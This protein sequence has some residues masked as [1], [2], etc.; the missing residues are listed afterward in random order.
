MVA[1]ATR[2]TSTDLK[3]YETLALLRKM[4]LSS[5]DVEAAVL[6]IWEKC[7]TGVA[8]ISVTTDA[9][10][11]AEKVMLRSEKASCRLDFI[12]GTTIGTKSL[13][14]DRLLVVVAAIA[15]VSNKINWS[16]GCV[17]INLDDSGGPDEICFSSHH[18][19]SWLIP[20]TDFLGSAAYAHLRGLLSAEPVA[21]TRK[22]P[23]AF[24][25]GASTGPRFSN[26][27]SQIRP[28]RDL[29]RIRVC[30]MAQHGRLSEI[31]DAGISHLV[32]LSESEKADVLLEGVVRERVLQRAFADYKVV[33]DIDG[34]ANAWASLFCKLLTGS[35]VLKVESEFGFRQ[36]YY[37]HLIAGEHFV[38]VRADLSDLEEQ[39]VWCLEHDHEAERIGQNGQ[40][41]ARSIDLAAG[42]QSL[43]D[44][45]EAAMSSFFLD[46]SAAGVNK[47]EP[48]LTEGWS[49]AE[50][51]YR[52]IDGPRAV[53]TAPVVGRGNGIR[54]RAEVCCYTLAGKLEA[55]R[56]TI[57]ANGIEV[58]N[59]TLTLKQTIQFN[60]PQFVVGR[61]DS[62]VLEILCVDA[63]SPKEFGNESDGRV[64]GVSFYGI[65]LTAI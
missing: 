8:V 50:A 15:K 24:W 44:T 40:N 19:F 63:R 20:D 48:F 59:G 34:N 61:P 57:L 32:Q 58:Y 43:A 10:V 2:S 13:F 25:R 33:L 46:F 28:W 47:I 1:E 23:L 64:L 53:V 38:P 39:L 41:L 16:L 60:I 6:A 27:A 56:M 51:H 9:K 45:L 4:L 35:L 5:S 52:W 49:W 14:F 30:Q 37:D 11:P 7:A 31:L 62:L 18:E 65:M 36:W 22:K 17:T 3:E 55:Q 54:V 12:I 42:L 29:P 21:W 26:G